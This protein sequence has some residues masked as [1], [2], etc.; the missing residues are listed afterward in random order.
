MNVRFDMEQN[1]FRLSPETVVCLKGL[2]NMIPMIST[3]VLG[4]AVF[5]SDKEHRG[6]NMHTVATPGKYQCLA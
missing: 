3:Q 1:F 5:S 6:E 4:H 2:F